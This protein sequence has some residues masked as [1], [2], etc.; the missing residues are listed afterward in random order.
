MLLNINED[1]NIELEKLEEQSKDLVSILNKDMSIKDTKDARKK[2]NRF[3][4]E[5]DEFRKSYTRD[6]DDFKKKIMNKFDEAVKDAKALKLEYDKIVKEAEEQEKEEKY[7]NITQIEGYDHYIKHFE[8]NNKWLNKSY[9][10]GDVENDIINALN[11]I[12]T[13]VKTKVLKIKGTDAQINAL[14]DFCEKNALDVMDIK[15]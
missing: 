7:Y 8:F 3:L 9:S 6:V 2:L 14:L 4:K 15:E 13:S 11:G 12:D 10:L 5:V 1:I